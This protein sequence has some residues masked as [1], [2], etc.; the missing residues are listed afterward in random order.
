MVIHL[1]DAIQSKIDVNRCNRMTVNYH[2]LYH[3]HLSLQPRLL[4]PFHSDRKLI[5]I[6]TDRTTKVS[7]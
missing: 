6:D 5:L 1:P 2:N 7:Q 3:P 4:N